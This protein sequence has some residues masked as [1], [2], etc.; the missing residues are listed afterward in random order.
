MGGMCDVL[1]LFV[2]L[3]TYP[4]NI[5][6]CPSIS[7]EEH[8]R[9]FE[10]VCDLAPGLLHSRVTKS[11]SGMHVTVMAELTIEYSEKKHAVISHIKRCVWIE[12]CRSDW[13]QS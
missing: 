6:L 4:G 12:S 1:R 7:L 9:G 10:A 5:R 8:L 11:L 2:C 3:H 13:F